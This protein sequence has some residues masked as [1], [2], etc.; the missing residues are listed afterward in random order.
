MSDDIADIRERLASIET[1]V[2]V[3]SGTLERIDG[4]LEKI[5]DRL[6]QQE[7]RAATGGA[8]TGGIVAVGVA[9]IQQMLKGGGGA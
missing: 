9:Y 6:R 1:T 2:N 5:D 4:R 7:I 3:Q 8:L